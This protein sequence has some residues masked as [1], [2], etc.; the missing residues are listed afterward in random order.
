MK[1]KKLAL[2]MANY[3]NRDGRLANGVG[4]DTPES[5]FAAMNFLIGQGI[6][7]TLCLPT[8]RR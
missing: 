1:K 6:G 4:L 5:V 8:V 2:I 7:L 3:P